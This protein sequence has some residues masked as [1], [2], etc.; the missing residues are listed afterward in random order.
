MDDAKFNHLADKFQRIFD[1]EQL[2]EIGR[3]TE[4]FERARKLTAARVIPAIVVTLA[5]TPVEHLTRF[6]RNFCQLFRETGCDYS[7]FHRKLKADAFAEMMRAFCQHVIE[8]AVL[9]VTKA[10][11]PKLERFDDIVIQDSTSLTL[12]AA[13]PLIERFPGRWSHRAPAAVQLN[14]TMSLFTDQLRQ[15]SLS[16]DK[17]DE[18]RFVPEADRLS[19]QLVLADAGYNALDFPQAI[20][21]EG[22][23]Y[24]IRFR[25]DANPLVHQCWVDGRRREHLEEVRLK[26]IV[27]RLE[28]HWV[29]LS[30]EWT[31]RDKPN[32]E[33]RLVLSPIPPDRRDE[34]KPNVAHMFLATNLEQETYQARELRELYRLRWQVELLIRDLKSGAHL[35]AYQTE[36]PAIAEGLIWA[37][38]AA[39][40]V[41]RFLAHMTQQVYRLVEVSTESTTRAL[42]LLL[43]ECIRQLIHGDQWRSTLKDMLHHLSEVAPRTHPRRDRKE[44][45]SAPGIRPRPP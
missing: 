44:G 36:K 12:K 5:T 30:V 13:D 28:G 1:S 35:A 18:T 4:F 7:P 22:G 14:L 45:R 42:Q 10:V 33:G 19:G 3:E 38:I 9:R 26:E 21:A 32:V 2:D 37:S 11:K 43:P 17:A 40:M 34:D 16:P 15:I 8:V 41:L 31:R 25:S 23:W 6:W 24:L 20:D 29:D 27:D 39:A